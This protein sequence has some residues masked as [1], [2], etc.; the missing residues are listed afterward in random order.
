MIVDFMREIRKPITGIIDIHTH[1]HWVEPFKRMQDMIRLAK[2]AGIGKLV[3]LGGNLDFGHRPTVPQVAKINDLTIALLRRWP[4]ELVGFCRLNPEHPKSSVLQEIDRCFATGL[5]KGIKLAVFPNARSTRLDPVM[6]KAGELGAA[7]LHHCWYKTVQKYEGESDP[8]DIADLAA[9]FPGIK[10]IMA[11]LSA[12]GCRGM[13]DVKPFKNV[14]VDTSGSPAI[15]GMVE[16]GVKVLGADRLLFGSD[17]FGR[18]F[19]VQLGR[20]LDADISEAQRLMIL[21]ENAVKLL[22]L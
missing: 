6:R 12:C 22:G 2:S 3:V 9:R 11:H 21:R 20:V 14:Y 8:T 5:F 13:L 17:A 18:D 1:P 19:S 15:T 10:I 7:V 16:Y 4:E